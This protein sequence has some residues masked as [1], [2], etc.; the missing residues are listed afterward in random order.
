MS[1]VERLL[2][3]WLDRLKSLFD[4]VFLNSMTLFVSVDEDEDDAVAEKFSLF[5]QKISQH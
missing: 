5:L 4:P 2:E 3:G 1:C